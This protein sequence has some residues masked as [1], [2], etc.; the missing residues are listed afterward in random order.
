MAAQTYTHI[1]TKHTALLHACKSCRRYN[2]EVHLFKPRNKTGLT[3]I[4][5]W[6]RSQPPEYKKASFA[7]DHDGR[8]GMAACLCGLRH[9]IT[10][11]ATWLQRACQM[12]H[13]C[14]SGIVQQ[15]PDMQP[16]IA[17]CD[18]LGVVRVLLTVVG[19]AVCS[20]HCVLLRTP[21][22]H[23][24]Y[25]HKG[26]LMTCTMARTWRGQQRCA[27]G[28]HSCLNTWVNLTPQVQMERPVIGPCSTLK[29]IVYGQHTADYFVMQRA[30]C[31]LQLDLCAAGHECSWL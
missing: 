30:M 8:E 7:C 13:A 22:C 16:C 10:S 15:A 26:A 4:H 31:T 1:H 6:L 21:H 25:C 5:S 27:A 14:T 11:S 18:F 9:C 29:L 2:L 24:E 19:F 23:L 12:C 17:Q 28:K 3:S 20:D